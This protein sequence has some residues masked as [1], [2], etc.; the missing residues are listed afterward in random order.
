[1]I[2]SRR[3][4]VSEPSQPAAARRS[5]ADL[6]M[7]AEMEAP[8]AERLALVVTELA[9]NLV[10]HATGG[11]LLLRPLGQHGEAGME[12]VS[13]DRGPGIADVARALRDGY[14]TTGSPGTGL[15][16]VERLASEFGIY[17]QPGKG[18]AVV[19]RILTPS[20]H[21]RNGQ[22]LSFGVVQV[23]KHGET[24]CGDDWVV[25]Q[26]ADGCLCAVADGLGHGLVAAQAAWPVIGAVRD[27]TGKRSPVELVRAGHEAAKPTR[28]AAL[29]VAVIE[30][31]TQTVR[32]AGVGNIAAVVVEGTE[33]RH[34][35]SHNG[36]L[37]HECRNVAEFSHRWSPK[38]IL[39]LH[40]DGIATHWDL[41]HFPGL[42]AQDPALIAAVLYRDFTRGRDDATIM[43]VKETG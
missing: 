30:V 3:V 33:R 32:F 25:R 24:V 23:S 7:Q 4:A 11:E 26:L 5:A 40:S 13:I 22:A 39:V 8:A 42:Q 20:S 18:T 10:K 41:S 43:V 28:G 12:V 21:G 37:G 27:A 14:S 36:V 9:T 6:A 17:S 31:E 15:G 2:L 34:L 1:M 16:A 38:A 35:V 19:A 29:G